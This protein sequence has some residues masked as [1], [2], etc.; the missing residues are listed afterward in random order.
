[1]AQLVA[2]MVFHR[3]QLASPRCGQSQSRVRTWT[4]NSST[5]AT[6]LESSSQSSGKKNHS[7][8]TL[9]PTMRSPLRQM[10][11]V[12][13]LAEAGTDGDNDENE[14]DRRLAFSPLF[15]CESPLSFLDAEL[16]EEFDG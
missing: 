10:T 1:M 16:G 5:C 15:F 8:P 11:L 13:E 7:V 2:N 12:S 9:M 4:G 14:K 6:A 3:H